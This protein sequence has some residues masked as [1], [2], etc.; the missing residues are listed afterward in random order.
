MTACVKNHSKRVAL[1]ISA[2][3]VGALSLG[4]AAPAVAFAANEGIQPLISEAD[5]VDQ[6]K[7]TKAENGQLEAYTMPEK[8]M[9]E[10]AAGTGQYLV[11]VE[12]TPYE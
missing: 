1:A 10:F 12:F 9:P 11:P 7:I 2:S 8:G 6:G 5:A 3:L 4:A